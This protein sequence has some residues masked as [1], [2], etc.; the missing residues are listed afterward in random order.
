MSDLSRRELKIEWARGQVGM[1]TRGDKLRGHVGKVTRGH[2]ERQDVKAYIH[3]M[4]VMTA[5]HID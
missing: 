5:G 3:A 4:S 2:G 1:V